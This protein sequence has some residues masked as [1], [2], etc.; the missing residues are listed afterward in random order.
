MNQ[1]AI[2]PALAAK[3]TAVVIQPRT[4]IATP[5][6]LSPTIPRLLVMSRMRSSKGGVENPG[7]GR[8]IAVAFVARI[9]PGVLVEINPCRR[10]LQ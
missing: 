6:T 3:I 7:I 2:K 4:L 10:A 9:E 5:F 8:A 1:L